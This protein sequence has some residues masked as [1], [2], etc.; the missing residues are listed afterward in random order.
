MGGA[1]LN[2]GP[3]ERGIVLLRRFDTEHDCFARRRDDLFVEV[4]YAGNSSPVHY[5][6]KLKRIFHPGYLK[7]DLERCAASVNDGWCR[8]A[9]VLLVDDCDHLDNNIGRLEELP[10][11]TVQKMPW[12]TQ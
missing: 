9:A 4:K 8:R 7:A 2:S 1:E 12:S 5:G 3:N 11:W 6:D 10:A